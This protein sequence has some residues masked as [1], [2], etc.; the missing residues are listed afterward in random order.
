DLKSFY[1]Q[2]WHIELD[3]RNIKG[4][5]GMNILSC[6]SPEMASKEIW[7]YLLAYNLIRLMMA[8]SSLLSDLMPRQLSFKHSLQLWSGYLQ[9][10][11][12]FNDE[13]F[14]NLFMLMSEKIVGNRPGRIE[15]RAVKRR[16]KPFPL[17]IKPRS[18]AREDIR[19]NGH[20]KKVK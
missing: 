14:Y 6:K 1:K 15:P 17:L 3:I 7:I 13:Q 5:L 4:T 16:P 8:Q 12:I 20:P 9:T 2:R 10:A 18:D 11:V 19:K